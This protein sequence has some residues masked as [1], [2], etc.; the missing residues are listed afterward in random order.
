MESRDHWPYTRTTH[1]NRLPPQDLPLPLMEKTTF[2]MEREDDDSD[3]ESTMDLGSGSQDAESYQ[4]VVDFTEDRRPQNP[5][6]DNMENYRKLLSLGVQLAEDDGHSHLT[7]GQTSRS[8]RSPY[9][10]TSRG[11][12]PMPEARTSSY[13]RGICEDESS[14]GVFMEKFIKAVSRSAKSG[15][16]R[17]PNDWPPRVPRVPRMPDDDWR[18][19]SFSK[20]EPVIQEWGCEGCVFAGGLSSNS[21]LV[22]RKRIRE[23]KRRCQLDVDGKGLVRGQK[24]YGKKK[25]FE[26]S[27]ARKGEHLGSLSLLSLTESPLADLGPMPYV[28]DECGR[29]FSVVSEFVEH[30]IMHTRE[31]LYEYGKLFFHSVPLSKFLKSQAQGKRSEGQEYGKAF[32]RSAAFTEHQ[33]IHGRE[34]L[35]A[36]QGQENEEAVMPS[37][38]LNQ[39]QKMSDKERFCE[40]RMCKETFLPSS[41]LVDHQKT[42]GREDLDDSDN[43]CG[44]ASKPSLS[45]KTYSKEKASGWQVCADT[46]LHNLALR[47]HQKAHARGDLLKNQT[48]VCEETFILVQPLKRHQKAPT[49]EKLYDLKDGGDAS[50][51]SSGFS[52]HPKLHSRKNR[53]E[54]RGYEKSVFPSM[55]FPESQKSHIITRPPDHE[56]Q[57][58][59]AFPISASP[60]EQQRFPTQELVCEGRQCDRSVIHRLAFTD[61]QKSH[62]AAE[63][64][65]L[66]AMAESIA[67]R[68][69]NAIA[70]QRARAGESAWEGQVCGRSVIQSVAAAESLPR[71]TGSEK[72]ESSLGVSDPNVQSKV[73]IRES[74][75]DEAKYMKYTVIQSVP[76][77]GEVPSEWK[78]EGEPSAPRSQVR[79][80]QKAR[81][82]KKYVECRDFE[83]SVMRSLPFGERLYEC[84]ECGES[85]V[86]SADLSEHQKVHD[87]EKPSGS[88]AYQRSVIRSLALVDPQTSSAQE[89]AHQECKEC[90]KCFATSEALSRH[91]RIFG[92]ERFHGRMTFG[93]SVI[94]SIGFEEPRQ[95]KSKE[96]LDTIYECKD[97]GLGFAN[98]TEFEDHRRVHGRQYLSDA[99]VCG[100]SV[101][102]TCSFSDTQRNTDGDQLFECPQCG[103]SF[104]SNTFFFEHQK[105]HEREPL[106]VGRQYSEAPARPRL[107]LPRPKRRR[108]SRK[109][110]PEW[111]TI[112]CQVCGQDFVH[113]SVLQEHMKTHTGEE[114]LERARRG[115]DT[116]VPGLALTEFQRSQ[117][118]E[119]NY[120]CKTCGESFLNHSDLRDHMRV[121]ERDQPFRY[122]TTFVHTSF[123]FEL[124]SSDSPFYECKDCGK[125]FI[126][127]T[128][129][130]KH[131]QLH[132]EAAA[133][134]LE[135]NLLVPQE[136]LRIQGPEVE[137]A[138]PEVETAEPE[139]GAAVP[140][141]EAAEPNGEAAGP[142]GAAEQ[143]DG[144]AELSDGD[145]DEP[146]G[147]GI[148][149]PEERA[150]ELEGDADE[151]DGAGLEDPE[152]ED[153]D[154]EIQV[155]EPY[156]D[157]QECAITFASNSAYG[158][159]L[160]AHARVILYEP[161]SVYGE[162]SRY[163]AHASTSA[164][165]NDGAD[166]KYFRCDVCGLL[167]SDLLSLA[168]HQNSH[169]G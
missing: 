74:F 115:E 65:Q 140:N 105:M 101:I 134:A 154:Q 169:T 33:K 168:R 119:K 88:K 20:R 27:Q 45:Q 90:G 30:Q 93:N 28:C 36:S 87:R 29:L 39:L 120:D 144:E 18:E 86:H 132:L 3:G 26:C 102:Q 9:P 31:E 51:Q 58:E 138:E 135:A 12:K 84:W 113:S 150:E 69:A 164:G 89:R 17:E 23:R 32:P 166:G 71:H 24:G 91:Q 34:C 19:V 159:H 153:E 41:A 7:Q 160:K 149:D 40:C 127:S 121:H 62:S 10:S 128:I 35:P 97:C 78:K 148:E 8:R 92:R 59:R 123:P 94:Q 77:A 61:P 100:S 108:A 56:E 66:K 155:E 131:Q 49:K 111:K 142:D 68:S 136:V 114:E 21:S 63:L 109:S 22:S 103:E 48:R 15:R 47:G 11:L 6:Q 112:R 122:G 5:I 130:V 147:V 44:E 82:K 60:K 163:T 67:V 46:F 146:D 145:G 124:P 118:E 79:E 110:P 139:V 116:V 37:P 80:Y 161:A 42:H 14:H 117:T 83:T 99:R 167:F 133:Q 81:E 143:L 141:L 165:A 76:R 157:C 52:E 95:D 158:E 75:F 104:I 162:S 85:F 96:K 156:Y 152:E 98:L 73:D 1:R 151:P 16:A 53:Y 137:A 72:G 126:H 64:S 125:S 70:Y 25:A 43:E 13:R 50:V 4:D 129:L 57:E 38:S 54:G 107:P 106:F 2:E 55:P